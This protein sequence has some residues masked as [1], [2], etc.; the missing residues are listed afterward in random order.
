VLSDQENRDYD[1]I[2]K[3]EDLTSYLDIE[4]RY[5][6]FKKYIIK[7]KATFVKNSSSL[8]IVKELFDKSKYNISST[9]DLGIT[10]N[11]QS[12]EGMDEFLPS[13]IISRISVKLNNE[14]ILINKRD[15]ENI[16]MPNFEYSNVYQIDK[17]NLLLEMHNS[18]GAA[19]YAYYLILNN[20]G[21]SEK[22]ILY[23]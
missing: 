15:Y 22:Y 10:L 19:G 21:K 1:T 6:K 9:Q 20:K 23:P 7:D 12:L 4:F 11:G 14:D 16:S 2:I 3:V 18:D 5:K 13:E 8:T 17:N